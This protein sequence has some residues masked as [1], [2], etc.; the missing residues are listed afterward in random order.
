MKRIREIPPL[1]RPMGNLPR[2]TPKAEISMP[3]LYNHVSLPERLLIPAFTRTA[4][5][6]RK[7]LSIMPRAHSWTRESRKSCNH[8][9]TKQM[10]DGSAYIQMDVNIN[11]ITKLTSAVAQTSGVSQHAWKCR[12]AVS[13]S[14]DPAP[15]QSTVLNALLSFCALPWDRLVGGANVTRLEPWLSPFVSLSSVINPR[16][17]VAPKYGD[18][19]IDHISLF[20]AVDRSIVLKNFAESVTNDGHDLTFVVLLDLFLHCD[21]TLN[22]SDAGLGRI[23]NRM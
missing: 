8:V 4:R 21:Y 2:T 11:D 16:S 18:H 23:A 20:H 10:L 12:H 9:G 6:P 7:F 17:G 13:P 14:E 19:H 5:P 1:D 22:D 3:D 15:A